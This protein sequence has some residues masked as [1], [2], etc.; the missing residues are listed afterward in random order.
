VDRSA[1]LPESPSPPCESADQVNQIFECDDGSEALAASGEHQPD[2]VLMDLKMAD[3]NGLASTRQIRHFF[4][5][6]RIVIISQWDD[7]QLRKEAQRAGAE[8]Y[9]TT[10]DLLPL[11]TILADA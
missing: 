1:P 6:A 4:P 11:R 3:L 8:G 7:A 10:S 5:E 2:L 9:F